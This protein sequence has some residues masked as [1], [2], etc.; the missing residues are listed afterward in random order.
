LASRARA[1]SGHCPGDPSSEDRLIYAD[2]LRRTGSTQE[3]LAQ[4]VSLRRDEVVPHDIRA[5][6]YA[7]S[8]Q[9]ASDAL[10]YPALEA[11]SREWLEFNPTDLQAGWARVLALFRLMRADEALALARELHLEPRSERD[12]HLMAA[13][14]EQASDPLTATKRD[15]CIVGSLRSA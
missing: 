6:A 12:A 15:R 11:V 8:A 4:L 10:D 2:A 13:T 9:I 1:V 7:S 14:L 3:A 5:D